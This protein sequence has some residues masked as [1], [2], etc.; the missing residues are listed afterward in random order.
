MEYKL[1]IVED[2]TIA[3]EYLKGIL[4]K[5]NFK[6]IYHASDSSTVLDIVKDTH[7]D[8]IFMD[9]N[10][11]GS[12]D[13][14]ECVKMLD[15][16]YFIPIIYT[17]AYADSNTIEEAKNDNVFGYLIKPFSM[18]SVEA[19]LKVALNLMENLKKIK[20]DKE[21]DSKKI[22][23]IKLKDGYD[24]CISSKTLTFKGLVI[25]L[26]NKEMSILDFLCKNPNQSI[27]YETLRE[28]IWFAKEISSSTIR[29][30]ISRLKK[31][32]PTL[33]IENISNYG[34]VLKV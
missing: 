15:K 21:I 29:D 12:L 32:V 18:D 2:N 25:N 33:C 24:Y 1:L 14:I 3:Y 5:L 11:D 8:L 4:Q 10:I 7:I 9:I 19:T 20:K 34:Y 31:K 26:T 30:T 16:V 13:G 28:E 17:T 6:N 23:N 27:S 22:E